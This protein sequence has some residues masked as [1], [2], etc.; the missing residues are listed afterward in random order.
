MGTCRPVATFNY[1]YYILYIMDA[2]AD[3]LVPGHVIMTSFELKLIGTN[4]NVWSTADN[5]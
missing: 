2:E 4:D 3:N 1:L 5:F